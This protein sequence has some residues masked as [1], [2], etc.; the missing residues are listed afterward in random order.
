MLLRVRQL[1]LVHDLRREVLVLDALVG[2]HG[3]GE[4]AGAQVHG[5][6]AFE[7]ELDQRVAAPPKRLR[8][9][10]GQRAQRVE[11][12]IG[13]VEKRRQVAPSERVVHDVHLLGGRY[14][15][16]HGFPLLDLNLSVPAV[17]RP[18]HRLATGRTPVRTPSTR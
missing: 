2:E 18:P 10:V 9:A 13:P 11:Q 14:D 4:R 15:K 17:A 5:A 6:D 7:V 16:A 3:R 12:Q 8:L 1:R